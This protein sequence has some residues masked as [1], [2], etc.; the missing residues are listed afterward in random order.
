[1][2]LCILLTWH[3]YFSG[4]PLVLMFEASKTSDECLAFCLGA[5]REDVLSCLPSAYTS[6]VTVLVE[7]CISVKTE[8]VTF[9]N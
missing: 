2:V 6:V 5:L 1:M 7:V 8:H 4:E 9:C 3:F